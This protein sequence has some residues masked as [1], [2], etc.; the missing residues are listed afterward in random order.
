MSNERYFKSVTL[1]SGYVTPH[2]VPRT[3]NHDLERH[4]TKSNW[5]EVKSAQRCNSAATGFL[6]MFQICSVM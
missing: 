3:I 6:L 1:F 4:L 5:L 2:P